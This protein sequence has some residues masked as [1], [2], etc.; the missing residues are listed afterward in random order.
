VPAL[1]RSEKDGLLVQR[2]GIEEQ[3]VHVENDGS[4]FTG[5]PHVANPSTRG[6][7]VGSGSL[8]S[9]HARPR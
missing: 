7:M 2:L 3:A 9:G 5:K 8:P 1:G 6:K 4:R